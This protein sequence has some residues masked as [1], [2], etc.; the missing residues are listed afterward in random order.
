MPNLWACSSVCLPRWHR[1]HRKGYWWFHQGPLNP[2][3]CSG[4]CSSAHWWSSR[5][6]PW[7]LWRG[8]GGALSISETTPGQCWQLSVPLCD[9]GEGEEEKSDVFHEQVMAWLN[10]YDSVSSLATTIPK[11]IFMSLQKAIHGQQSE[12]LPDFRI[13]QPRLSSY[14]IKFVWENK[15]CCCL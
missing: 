15:F 1:H 10:S 3:R 11:S 2:T 9:K 4:G 8:P 12:F 7:L 14:I 6:L 5:F 13:Q